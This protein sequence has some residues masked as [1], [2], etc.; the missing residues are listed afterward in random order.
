[1]NTFAG[2]FYGIEGLA[3][4]IYSFYAIKKNNRTQ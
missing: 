2:V 3:F 4:G 1:M